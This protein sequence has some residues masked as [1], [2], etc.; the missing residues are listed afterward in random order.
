MSLTSTASGHN[1]SVEQDAV[2]INRGIGLGEQLRHA[3]GGQAFDSIIMI[4]L[5]LHAQLD[6]TS[7]GMV[8]GV[9]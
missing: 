7:S 1:G 5:D 6:R 8:Q 4:A 2:V 3:V 9:D